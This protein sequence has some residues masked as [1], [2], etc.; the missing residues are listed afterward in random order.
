MGLEAAAPA[1]RK[2]GIRQRSE[3]RI[4][5]AAIEA[6]A[7]KG[8]HGATIAEIASALAM[9]TATIHYYFRNKQALYD[10]V[11]Q[12]IVELW[13]TEIAGIEEGADPLQAIG[14]YVRSKM[15]FSRRYPHASRVFANDIL[16][17]NPHI[18]GMVRDSIRPIVEDKC[19]VIRRWIRAGHIRPVEPLHLFF[20]IWGA[21]EFYANFAGEVAIFSGK[22]ELSDAQYEQAVRTVA[23]II[24][25]GCRPLVAAG[26]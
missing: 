13:F 4:I 3:Q 1:S 26:A 12:Q 18:L 9:P 15:A 11:L 10:A 23:G 14:D 8:A 2:A 17:G 20:M 6:F 19:R 25:E 22:D 5:A 24:V 7:N 16:G 21:T